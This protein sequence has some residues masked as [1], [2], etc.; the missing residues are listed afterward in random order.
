VRSFY[1]DH[2]GEQARLQKSIENVQAQPQEGLVTKDTPAGRVLVKNISD[3]SVLTSNADFN[4]KHQTAD[5][6]KDEED[7]NKA[8]EDAGPMSP[9]FQ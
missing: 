9:F 5:E 8:G 6:L 3:A 1:W 2:V 4:S 7:A